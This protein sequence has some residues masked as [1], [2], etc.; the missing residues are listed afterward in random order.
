MRILQYTGEKLAPVQ[1]LALLLLALLLLIVYV[2]DVP[3][4]VAVG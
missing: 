1:F 2:L 4:V 3:S